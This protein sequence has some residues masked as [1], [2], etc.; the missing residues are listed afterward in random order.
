LYIFSSEEKSKVLDVSGEVNTLFPDAAAEYK[1]GIRINFYC[2][3]REVP[4]KSIGNRIRHWRKEIARNVPE[5]ENLRCEKIEF[6]R[7][8]EINRRRRRVK[9]RVLSW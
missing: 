7:D 9:N 6:K 5:K 2:N 3:R 1:R 8:G 4:T